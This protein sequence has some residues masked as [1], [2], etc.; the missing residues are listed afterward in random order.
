MRVSRARL[1]AL[2]AVTL[3]LGFAGRASA[4]TSDR[5]SVG[6]TANDSYAEPFYANDEGFFERARLHVD[7]QQFPTGAGVAA[8]VAGNAIDIGITNPIALANAVE[9]GLPFAF[10]AAAG[11]YNPKEVALCVAADSPIKT[12]RDLNGKTLGTTA[13]RGDNSLEVS[14]WIDQMGGDSSTLRFVE[15]PMSTMAAAIVRGTVAAAEISEPALSIAASAGGIRVLGHPMDV[16]GSNFMVG[17][18]FGRAEWLAA[19]AAMMHR[20]VAAIYQ[21]ARWANAHPSESAAILAKYAKMDIEVVRRMNRA[22]YAESFQPAMFQRCL[23]IGY[24]YKYLDRQFDAM[25]LVAN[26]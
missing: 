8:A 24:K 18:W 23:D 22:E 3:T 13:L 7:V 19:N 15:M 6:S 1:L 11:A 20:F 2:S 9:H 4:Q 25:R 10:F 26:V 12:V 21:T 16:Y 14:A 5:V 17:G